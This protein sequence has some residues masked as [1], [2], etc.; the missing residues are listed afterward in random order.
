[1]I[2][3]TEG[4]LERDGERI[5]Y[6]SAGAGPVLVLSH[7]LGGN[8]AVWFQQLPYFAQTYRVITWDQRGF[9]RS[10]S[11]SGRLGPQPAVDD[12]LALLDHL[13]VK[14]AA[15]VGQS[16]GGWVS[17]GAALRDPGRIT[18]AVLACS[19]AGIPLAAEPAAD[20]GVVRSQVGARPLGVH[21]AIGERLAE[22]DP[23]RAYLY[24][25]LGSFGHRPGDGEFARMLHDM[26]FG[27][28]ELA[29]LETPVLM[30]CGELDQMMT[31]AR[32]QHA[33][34]RLRHVTVH[35]FAGRG[36]SVYFE[37]PDA[38]NATVGAFLDEHYLSG[39]A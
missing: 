32:I 16:M 38:W 17:M 39:T 29:A 21:P 12:L 2:E 23:A 20:S 18:T 4:Y 13:E 14:Q 7:G 5:W 11:Q 37:D 9:G 15:L 22:R 3:R 28:P 35:E 6:E 19:T 26:T 27:L 24:Q 10:S 25:A 31:P 33:A 1:M 34:T 30:L 36:H 8:A